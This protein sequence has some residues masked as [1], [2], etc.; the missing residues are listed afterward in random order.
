M[1]QKS[2]LFKWWRAILAEFAWI[3]GEDR[4]GELRQ[5]VL[6]NEWKFWNTGEVSIIIVATPHMIINL[7]KREKNHGLLR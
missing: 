1:A 6:R 3:L 5:K 7:H 2:D 4:F